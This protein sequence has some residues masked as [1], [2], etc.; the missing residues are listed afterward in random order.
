MG[1]IQ[2]LR[3]RISRLLGSSLLRGGAWSL[4]IQAQFAVVQLLSGIL[5]ARLLGPANFGV[6]SFAFAIVSM[7]QVMPNN[8]LESVVIRYGAQYRAEQSWALLKGLLRQMFIISASYGLLTAAVMAC[9]VYF[10]WLPKAAALSPY[11]LGAAALPMIFFPLTAYLGAAARS[12]GASVLGQIP[13]YVVRPWIWLVLL[14]VLAMLE[15]QIL[16]AEAVMYMQGV[17]GFVATLMGAYWLLKCLPEQLR[18]VRPTYET[19]NWFHAV[20]PY[21]LMGGL[22]LINTQAD[23]LML[24]VLSNAHETGLYRVAMNGAN[25]LALSLTAANLYIAPRISAMHSQQER[26]K[27]QRLLMLS[28]RST[29]G[30]ALVIAC[31][32]WFW[33]ADLLVLVFGAVYL[34]ALWPLTILCLG[35]LINVGAGSVGLVLRMTGHQVDAVLMAGVAAALNILLNGI[36]I[37]MYGGNGAAMA[38]A[39]TMLIWNGLMLVR[40]R[41]RLGVDTSIFYVRKAA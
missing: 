8:G 4:L 26:E 28:V 21:S 1:Y 5:L 18:H 24:G 34:G 37:P 31:V 40:V 22:M 3:N 19:S 41:Q 20:L 38:T 11:V 23:I 30:F 29:F 39:A 36:L 14:L 12:V 25:L 10:D 32:F 2:G 35:Q 15:P 16:N 7:V 13:L 9:A 6:Y 33:G 27:L 17:A